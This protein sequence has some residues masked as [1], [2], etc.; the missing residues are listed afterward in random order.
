MEQYSTEEMNF[1]GNVKRLR[2]HLQL[3]KDDMAKLCGVNALGIRG[4]EHGA[5]PATLF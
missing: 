4:I 2:E 5:C 1:C 3:S